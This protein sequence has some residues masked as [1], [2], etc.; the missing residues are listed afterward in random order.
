[1]R[2]LDGYPCEVL[3]SA[4]VHDLLIQTGDLGFDE[5]RELELKGYEAAQIVYPLA[6]PD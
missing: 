2:E 3:V 6:L 4:L 1:M 5:R